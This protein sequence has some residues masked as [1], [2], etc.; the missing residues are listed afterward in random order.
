MQKFKAL[1]K[2]MHDDLKDSEM[3]IN[4]AYEIR[5]A[6]SADKALAD[7]LA[8]YALFRLNH[9][10]EFHNLFK[11]ET[12]KMPEIT[13]K[14]VSDCMWCETHEMMQEWH[15]KIKSKINKY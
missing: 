11:A 10:M 15:E 13:E 8:K 9:F 3:M 7:E 4:Y 2:A 12:K 5:E 1:Y 6:N 14:T